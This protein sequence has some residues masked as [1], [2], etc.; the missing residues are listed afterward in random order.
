MPEYCQCSLDGKQKVPDYGSSLCSS[1]PC[2]LRSLFL[3]MYYSFQTVKVCSKAN[4][5][6]LVLLLLYFLVF[7]SV[8]NIVTWR[9]L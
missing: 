4:R 3:H 6:L 5:V 9:A 7:C 2:Q 8:K 1:R